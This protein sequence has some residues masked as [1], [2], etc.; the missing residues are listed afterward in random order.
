M[1]HQ[2]QKCAAWLRR[3]RC[4]RNHAAVPLPGC[5]LRAD[6]LLH[7]DFSSLV[8]LDSDSLARKEMPAHRV[9]RSTAG[10]LEPSCPSL[11]CRTKK[12]CGDL[13]LRQ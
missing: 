11:S 8:V 13:L 9:R 7:S 10:E 12:H 5:P 4:A 1:Q 6:P 3:A 2:L